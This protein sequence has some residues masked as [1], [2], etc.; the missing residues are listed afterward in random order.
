LVVYCGCCG[1]L[2]LHVTL[3]QVLPQGKD[4]G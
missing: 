1:D 2:H 4:L 3:T